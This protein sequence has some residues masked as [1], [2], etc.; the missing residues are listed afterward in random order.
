MTVQAAVY[1]IPGHDRNGDPVDAEGNP[2]SLYS[3]STYLGTLEVVFS[4]TQ[5][6]PVEP[7]LT[8]TSGATVDCSE[9][10]DVMFPE[11]ADT[12][13]ERQPLVLDSRGSQRR[14]TRHK[15]AHPRWG[16]RWA[17]VNAAK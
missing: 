11:L 10:A 15:H 2:V 5:A 14:L 13:L 16:S 6:T 8:G 4:D 1:R 12:R 7:R 9:T 17:A 3:S